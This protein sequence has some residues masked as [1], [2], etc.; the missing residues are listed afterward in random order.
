MFQ[1]VFERGQA[2]VSERAFV[3]VGV[4]QKPRAPP[5]LACCNFRASGSL[6]SWYMTAGLEPIL[7][8][9]PCTCKQQSD[10]NVS[11]LAPSSVQQMTLSPFSS[12]V[13]IFTFSHASRT[14]NILGS[15]RHQVRYV[16]DCQKS[17]SCLCVPSP[18]HP[19]PLH[20][21]SSP[22]IPVFENESWMDCEIGFRK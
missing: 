21:P 19:Y 6:R 3:Q 17:G 11:L 18:L 7:Q 8:P 12:L 16:R 4:S 10:F 9:E 22:P 5:C 13:G 1:L 15:I 14:S 2:L 20:P